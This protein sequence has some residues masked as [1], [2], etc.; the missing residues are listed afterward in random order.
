LGGRD[1]DGN[2]FSVSVNMSPADTTVNVGITKKIGKIGIY[3]AAYFKP[4]CMQSEGLS[5][6]LLSK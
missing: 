5:S 1:G 6:T 4:G 3:L 2:G